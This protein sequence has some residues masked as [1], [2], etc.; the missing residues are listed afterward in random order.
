MF[1]TPAADLPDVEP[2]DADLQILTG[3]SWQAGQDYLEDRLA[4]LVTSDSADGSNVRRVQFATL[5]RRFRS[6]ATDLPVA[7]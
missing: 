3:W 1:D 6:A 4:A 2:T 7:A 5:D